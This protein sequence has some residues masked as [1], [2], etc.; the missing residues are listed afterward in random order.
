MYLF[1]T[2]ANSI[3]VPC[4][5]YRRSIY[6]D[7]T[8]N[9]T[10][11]QCRS[12]KFQKTVR[13]LSEIC[14]KTVSCKNQSEISH[15]CVRSLSEISQMQNCVRSLLEKI[16]KSVRNVSVFKIKQ[17]Q[18]SDTFIKFDT[19]LMDFQIFSD[20]FLTDICIWQFS[21]R[22]L[23]HLWLFSDTFL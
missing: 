18:L 14:Q 16:W 7:E 8:E 11:Y 20:R 2:W 12:Q 13:Y 22:I 4:T 9:W 17:L 15:K 6:H 21:D 5:A 1:S 3:F 19:F 23:T 10:H